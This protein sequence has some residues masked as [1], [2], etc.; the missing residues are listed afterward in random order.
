MKIIII[1]DE[2]ITAL[3]LKK[4]IESLG[5]EVVAMFDNG[6]E[7]FDYLQRGSVDLIFMDIQIKG[8][9]DGVQVS[10]IIHRQSPEIRFIFLTSYKDSY[11]IASAQ[12][13]KPSG[14]MIKPVTEQDIEAI[15]MV[16][17]GQIQKQDNAYNIVRIGAYI[18]YLDTRSLNRAGEY[19]HLTKNEQSYFH[20]LIKNRGQHVS[21]AQLIAS[22]W[23]ETDNRVTSLRELTSR[24]RKKLTGLKL[25]NIP[26]VG[27]TLTVE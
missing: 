16:V 10:H 6:R 4:S 1:E 5:H 11:T 3:F 23:T 19:I 2:G 15:L 13:V 8:S 26:N 27:Y 25:E 21:M 24:M 9:M 17:Q 7:L 12:E 22:I 18:Y 14:Y 20:E